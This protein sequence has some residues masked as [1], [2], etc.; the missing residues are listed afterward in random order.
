MLGS[1]LVEYLLFFF[2][3]AAMDFSFF[4]NFEDDVICHVEGVHH[5]AVLY[6]GIVTYVGSEESVDLCDEFVSVGVGGDI[7]FEKF[8]GTECADVDVDGELFE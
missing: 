5:L 6:G 7:V 1:V 4:L 2:E 3:D 8:I